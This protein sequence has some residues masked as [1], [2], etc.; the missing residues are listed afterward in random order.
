MFKQA[1][2]LTGKFQKCKKNLKYLLSVEINCR[3]FEKRQAEN[4]KK[5]GSRP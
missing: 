5:F 3:T 4:A 2:N 1:F